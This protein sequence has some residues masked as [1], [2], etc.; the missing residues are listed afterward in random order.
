MWHLR[1]ENQLRRPR[2]AERP[3]R[4]L[5][6]GRPHGCQDHDILSPTLWPFVTPVAGDD[7]TKSISIGPVHSGISCLRKQITFSNLLMESVNTCPTFPE[8]PAPRTANQGP[9]SPWAVG[10]PS[11]SPPAVRCPLWCPVSVRRLAFNQGPHFSPV[12]LK[13]IHRGLWAADLVAAVP[14]T[15]KN[16]KRFFFNFTKRL[17]NK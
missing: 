1:T 10:R 5:G 11:V 9:L 12:C 6:R 3:P 8:V 2:R 4:F 16:K 14:W 15:P 13:D 7:I 17:L